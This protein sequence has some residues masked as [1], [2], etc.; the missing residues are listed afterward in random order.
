MNPSRIA[1]TFVVAC[2][3]AI[4]TPLP[5]RAAVEYTVTDLGTLA[6]SPGFVQSVANG[7]SDNGLVTGYSYVGNQMHAFVYDG[8]MHDLGPGTGNGINDSGEVVGTDGSGNIF[9]YNGTMQTIGV[10][11]AGGINNSG[12]VTGSLQNSSA[13]VYDGT[14]HLLP[15]P[16]GGTFGFGIAINSSGAVA[17]QAVVP[18]AVFQHEF[19]QIAYLYDGTLHE[20][21]TNS[22]TQDNGPFMSIAFAL[23]DHG[24][25][26]GTD[27]ALPQGGFLYSG[28]VEHNIGGIVPMGIN[29][30]DQVV[31][32]NANQALMYT[33]GGGIV[34]LNTLI[35]PASGWNLQ[36][37]TAI[38]NVGQIVG[39]G[40]LN[41][42]PLDSRAFLLTPVP[43]PSTLILGI[44]GVAS[45]AFVA[46]RKKFRRA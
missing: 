36:W 1:L 13:F 6:G 11:T 5:G 29:N 35:N 15:Q 46:L 43:E 27:S 7:L 22:G 25:V 45:L 8:T 31:G 39:Y 33:G 38:N 32:T 18:S 44:V 28:G 40:T 24:D 17:G 2:G 3:L 14:V 9:L 4:T 34:N 21:G 42:D 37:A 26:V 30:S 10:G 16:P 12:E 20:V 19:A 23:N 41:G